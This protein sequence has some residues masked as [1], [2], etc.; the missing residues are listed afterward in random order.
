MP[1]SEDHYSD[2]N[3]AQHVAFASEFQPFFIAEKTTQSSIYCS[4]V[5]KMHLHLIGLDLHAES[6]TN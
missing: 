1:F 4:T 5:F 6:F 2:F 3:G